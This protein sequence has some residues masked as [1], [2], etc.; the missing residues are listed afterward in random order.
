M[1]VARRFMTS[2]VQPVR[3]AV[4]GAAGQIGY[5]LLPRIAAGEMLGPNQP[6]ILHLLER[7]D[8]KALAA[9]EGVVMELQDC[10]F[11][12]LR[13]VVAT[14]DINKAFDSVDYAL[15]VGAKP[16]GPGME[17]ADVLKDNAAIFKV[18]GRALNESAKKSVKV[19]V[20]GNPANTNAM[21]AAANAPNIPATNFTSMMRLDHDRAMAQIALKLGASSVAD[22][23]KLVVWGNHSATQ[24]PDLSNAVIKGKSVAKNVDQEWVRNTFIPTVQQRGAAIIKA[25]GVSSAASAANAAIAHVRDWVLG[26]NGRIVSMGIP[27]DGN[28]YGVKEGLLFGFPVTCQNGQYKIVEGLQWDEFGKGAI[29]RTI[30]ELQE[31]KDAVKH[32]L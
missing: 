10:A 26:T 27:S 9:L 19:C 8:P 12:L 23:E 3:V 30:K 29:E 6:V 11:P 17:R 15:L 24:Y 20:V 5:A 21:I 32:L 14:S 31:E 16:R 25:R 13:G 28:P 18:Q 1:F 4:T 2:S 7:D 22:V